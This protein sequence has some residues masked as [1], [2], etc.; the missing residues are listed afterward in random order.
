MSM[1]W[2]SDPIVGVAPAG[3]M[4]WSNDP[5]VSHAPQQPSY[6]GSILPFS[7]DAQ[8]S[9][10]F[11][12][13]AG[14][15]GSA[16]RAFRAPGDALTGQMPVIGP[17]GHTTPQAIDSAANMAGWIASPAPMAATRKMPTVPSAQELK[18]AGGAGYD[19][20]R[21]SGLEMRGDA[22]AQMAQELQQGLQSEHGIIA[23]T[24]PKTFSVLDELANPP[25]GG[26]ATIPGIEAARR[27]LSSISME[28][29]TEGLAAGRAVRG[30]DNFMSTL[31]DSVL[32][33]SSAGTASAQ[34][35]ADTLR[36]ARANYAAA[37]RSN[38]L[39]GALDRATT[40]ISERAA[41]RAQAS[42][43][44]RNLDNAIRQRVA[45]LLEKPKEV[46]GFSDDELAA[47][48]AVVEGGPVRNTAR[49]VGNLLG[50]GGGLGQAFTAGLGAAGGAAAGGGPGAMIGAVLP[51]AAGAVAKV[52][53]NTLARRSLNAADKMVRQRSPLYQGLLDTAPV[54]QMQSSRDAVLLRAL[55][56]GLL[57]LGYQ[58]QERGG[59]LP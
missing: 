26:V 38:D 42:N 44:G 22:V 56:P 24:A 19:A 34:G 58:P 8:G 49:Y 59:L 39:T 5:I 51:S 13:N 7:T 21:A 20:A 54:T 23:K 36:T 53:E 2:E 17:D 55:L 43:S 29:G 50:G 28:G 6:T 32:A 45:S 12:P 40:G 11:D 41:A 33:P 52:V 47:L 37:Q 15:I 10:S 27:G 25:A 46:A 16:I 31:G 1:P 35:V 14:I 48:R 18:A 30:L 3:A 57:G 4:P 9:V